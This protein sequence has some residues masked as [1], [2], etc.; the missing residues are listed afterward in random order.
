METRVLNDLAL[1]GAL[2][3]ETDNSGF[4]ENPQIGTLLLK[5]QVLYGYLKIGGMETWYPFAN[6]TQSYIHTQG[7]D[8][9]YWVVNH[10]LNTTNVWFQV[11]DQTGNILSVGKED[12]NA[13]SFRLTFTAAAR[14]TVMVVAPD[15]VDVPVV[16]ASVIE[17]ANGAVR[18]SSAG[19]D[20]VGSNVT[21]DG[22]P[23]L[24]AASIQPQIDASI[25]AVVGAAPS[26]LNTLEEIAAQLQSDENA[27]AA[28]ATTVAGKANAV[29]T[30][31][32]SSVTGLQSALDSK[33]N[34]S[35]LATVATSG[36]YA[37]LTG[38]PSLSTVATSGSYN[39]LTNKP[40]VFSGNYVDLAGKPTLFSGSY[41]DLT[42]KPT[43]FSGAYAD[44]TGKPV[45]A[46]VATSGAYADL[47]GKPSLSTVA[48]SGSYADLTNKPTIP[49]VPT[50]VSAFTN[51]SGFQTAAQVTS[52]VATANTALK[53]YTDA[54]LATKVNSSSLATVATSGS[55]N[56][57]SGKPTLFSGAY[58]DLTGKPTL[59][60]GA[61]ADLTGKPTIPT[62]PTAVS[63]FTNDSGFQTAAQVSSTVA[64]ANTSMKSYVDA[65]VA[66]AA[67]NATVT[68]TSITN[69]LGYTPL[70]ASATGDIL[71]LVSGVSNIGSPTKK[72]NAIYTK[73]MHIDA[74]TLYVDGVPVLGSSANTIQFTADVNQGMRIATSGSGTTI[75]ESAA[76]T[77]IKTTGQNADVLIQSGGQGS[78]TRLT[79][80]TQVTL[81]APTVAAVGN[82][83]V[84]GN[85]T[86][87][88]NFSV[89]GTTTTVDT[90]NLSVKDNV[91]T[92]NKGEN[93]S[94]VSLR[95][96]GLDVDRGDLARQ[97]IVWDETAGKWKIGETNSEVNIATEAFVSAAVN[98]KANTSSLA[99]VATSGSYN[100]LT[101]KPTS[102]S[103]AY[104]DLTGKPSLSTVATS[105][106]YNDLTNKPT[107][108][109]VPTVV[110][111]FT[112]DSGFQTAAQVSSTVSTAN[113]AL[114]SYTDAGLATKVNSSSLATV[115][116]SGAYADLS[117]K[118]SLSTVATSGSYNDL[119]NKPTV[120]SGNYVDLSGKPTIPT[121]PT[122]VSAFTNDSGYQTAA[123]VTSTVST[124]NTS[125][126]S[127]V[128]AGLATKVNSSSLATVA[129]SGSYADLTNKPTIPT[130]PTAV[131]AF[132]N[133]SG[134][135]TSAQVSST[136]AAANTS[137]KSYTDAAI[138][139]A[140][141]SLK[142]Y[143]DAALAT[144][145][146]TSSLATV[147]TSGSYNDLTN[148]PTIPTVPTAVSAF[149]NDSGYQTSSQVSSTVSTANTSLK[150]YT[151]AGLATKV[152]TS[153]LATVATSGAYADLSGKPTI[154]TV[155]TVVSAFTNDAGYANTTYVTSAIQAVVGAAP[156]ALDTLAE[157]AAQLQN[158]ESVTSALINT[159]SGKANT[160]YVD[161]ADSGIRAFVNTSISTANTSLKSYTDAAISTANTSLKSYT[162]AAL[163]T[164]VNSSSL[165]TV[166][167]SGAYADLSGK[168]TIPTVPTAVS[169]FTNDSAY[170]NTTFVTSTV[171]TANTSLKSY[172]DAAISTA[173]TSLKSYT[174]AALATKVNTS[175]LATVATSGSYADLTNKPTI[176]TVPTAVSAFTNDAN[177]ANTTF[178]T[179]AVSAA[180]TSMKSYVDAAVASAGSGASS[181]VNNLTANTVTFNSGSSAIGLI[182]ANTRST[183]STSQVSVDSFATATYRSA[184]YYV[185]MTSS[186]THHVLEM[187]VVH[188]GTTV[189]MSQ[190]GEVTTGALLGSFDASITS[191][192]LNL[193]F[194]PASSAATTV[195]LTRTA[196]SV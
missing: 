67:T 56:D 92:L 32:I 196:V 57:L 143:T 148:K 45:L 69:A 52:A 18:L 75:L 137:L 25:A 97:R 101:N 47:S 186:T 157:I 71:P 38:K 35:S 42:N 192:T 93:G 44:L 149:T 155:P 60:S 54:G 112:N 95:Y 30:H 85:L 145:V 20:V 16:K 139:T 78:L 110:S 141:T 171:S 87:A 160:T 98:A 61:Y 111:A 37:D 51:D 177:Y 175:S 140:N 62:V 103:G 151:D 64:T 46:S 82:A 5:D 105:G 84:S 31:A 33:A 135:Q 190:Y 70:N 72:F 88:G 65:A 127:Y 36:A 55:Y 27:A 187:T 17:V 43:L 80:A 176:P 136:V 39:D 59:F 99:A 181:T 2:V 49:T 28:L 117:G 188:D 156:A 163:A 26:T 179:S 120:F 11:K 116:T 164:K 130:V 77:T 146:N 147:A 53:S 194:T 58:A 10:G 1:Y 63:A 34:T 79:S 172:T 126:K 91:I 150:S 138:S 183:S 24:T 134:Y 128:D 94:G 174:D 108:P 29:H 165:A 73:E 123:Q 68:S 154:P 169:A 189:F 182:S 40:T 180:N 158:D 142:S 166:A 178:V 133:D 159:V 66:S 12:I 19:V 22:S 23:V 74:N 115:A 81:T 107:I 102:F 195:K 113:T 76:G 144:K 8:S 41:N 173:N 90:T 15:T 161:T 83:T 50:A 14:G 114:K 4:P 191:G 152:N 7:M 96:S 118:P 193:Q 100:D 153:S 9:L 119:T 162:D 104:A 125:M 109:T 13:N 122:A 86:V 129:T 170:A 3:M 6:K 124:A 48:T 131:S 184:K 185:Q 168:P 89:S 167:T 106:S 121:V 21:V 132:T